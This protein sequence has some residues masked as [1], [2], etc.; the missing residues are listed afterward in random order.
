MTR[1][2]HAEGLRER[3][4]MREASRHESDERV[5]VCRRTSECDAEY[6]EPQERCGE[7]GFTDE[8]SC[9]GATTPVN[10]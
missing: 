5:H 4:N 7:C 6:D 3:R 1:K 8:H 10:R 2:V 9:H